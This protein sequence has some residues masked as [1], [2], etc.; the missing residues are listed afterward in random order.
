IRDQ[1]KSVLLILDDIWRELDLTEVGIP[2]GDEHNGCKLVVTSRYLDV[3]KR[4]GTQ[5]EF[6]LRVLLEKDSW[7]LFEKMAG[8]VVKEFNIKPI[9]EKVAQCCAGL[10]LLIITVAKGLRKKDVT[11][12]KDAL[13][14]L[15]RFDHQELQQKVYP[16]LE[17]SYNYLENDELKLLFLFIGSF[18]LNSFH[19][20]ALF[21]CCW[22]LGFYKKMRKLKEA[23]NRHYK[24]INDLRASSLL[25]EGKP[26]CVEMHDVVLD[27]AKSI[28]SRFHP[29][30]AVPRYT[31][32][33]EWPMDE[34]QTCHYIIIPLCYIDELPEKLECPE[35]ELLVLGN[36]RVHAY[37]E[38]PD[39]FFSMMKKVST[40][41]L[42]GMKFTPSLPPSLCLLKSLCSLIL[43]RCNLGDIRIVG[44]LK[45]LEILSLEQSSIDEL[46]EEI[47]HLTRLRL[48][49]LTKCSQLRIIPTNLISS[50]TCLEELYMGGCSIEWAV[51]GRESESNNASLG[52]LRNLH[53]LTTLE[54]LIQDT[55]A[56]PRDLR[57][58]EKLER[59]CILI[60]NMW[61]WHL[62]SSGAVGENSRT[63]KLTDTWCTSKDL[64]TVEDLSFAKLKGV[65]DVLYELNGE[66]F[67]QLKHLHIQDSDEL[68]HII[69]SRG[70]ANRHTAFPN[71]E[72]LVLRSLN[73]IKEICHGS[74]PT[75]S[76]EKLQVIKVEGCDRLK[77]LFLYSH[78]KNL[79]QLCKLEISNCKYMKEIIAMEKQED[80]KEVPKIVLPELRSLTLEKL[81]MF[82]SFHLSL[83]VDKGNPSIESIPLALFNQQVMMPKLETLELRFMDTC[84]IWDDQFLVHSCIQNLTHLTL[85]M[86]KRL[87]SLFSPSVARGLVKLKY[88]DIKVCTMLQ[89]IFVHDKEVTVADYILTLTV[90]QFPNLETLR[91]SICHLR[92][93]WPNRLAPNSFCKLDKINIA[94]CRSLDYVFPIS[95]A[96]ELQQI[97]F[98]KIDHCA[99]ENIVEKGDS[100]DLMH[101]N[102]EKLYVR[103]CCN[104]KTIVPSSVLFSTLDKLFVGGCHG[105]VNILTASTTIS[106]PKLRILTIENCDELE[107]I[108]GSKNEGDAPRDEIVF[109]NL[110][111][112]RL[113]RLPRLKSFCQGSYDI[114]FRSLQMVRLSECPM[115]E[116]FCHGNLTT[117]SHTMVHFGREAED[118]WDGDLNTTIRT[119]FIKTNS[120]QDLSSSSQS[121]GE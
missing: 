52:E 21:S 85:L 30:Y 31:K 113:N 46:P 27:V 7:N 12:W 83:N 37:L 88:L 29:T 16:T 26:G 98:L 39:N 90:V 54:I 114:K 24:L 62:Q 47:G 120:K 103:D 116:T 106:L 23:R 42:C 56:L 115:M 40:L 118:H 15:E 89:E 81:T 96:M 43:L 109:M 44:K 64:T 119:F 18:G 121:E 74:L 108:Y 65:K 4:M 50:L 53:L 14:Q 6:N 35:L 79:S 91:I 107:E 73:N 70:L 13:V 82:Q 33:K 38:V 8:K 75:P 100:C 17:L 32:M 110:E 72:I 48:L 78:V 86:C 3:L 45:N 117:P 9:A 80:E 25:L 20:G 22:G 59:Y 68:L 101:V 34:L 105:V 66:G 94:Y 11:A 60:G 111:I 57:F 5:K 95:L 55:S 104:I 84:K 69:N 92:S 19:I 41:D 97:E 58:L 1:K 28:A 77:N 76:F 36:G 112:L 87:T 49:N 61:E 63:L 51:E 99:I 10:P 93:I 102:L 2:F 67:P 71:L